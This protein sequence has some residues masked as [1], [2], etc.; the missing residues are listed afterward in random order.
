MRKK[1]LK[2]TAELVG[3][4]LVLSGLIVCMCET[5]MDKQLTAMFIG[6]GMIFAGAVVAVLVNR[7]EK[8]E[9]S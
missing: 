6:M 5:E 9:L 2:G 1:L 4:S 3:M 8:D 7:G